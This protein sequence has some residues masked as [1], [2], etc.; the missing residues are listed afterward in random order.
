VREDDWLGERL[1]RTAW[2]VEDCDG[3]EEIT[4]CGSGFFQAKVSAEWVARVGEL[5][6]LGFRAIDVNVILRRDAGISEIQ[7]DLR[8]RDAHSRDRASVL[9][10]ATHDYAVSRFHLDPA[11]PDSV[12]SAIKRDWVDNFFR[13]GRGDRLLVVDTHE[14]PAGFLLVV[15]T[16]EAS[17]IDLIAVATGAQGKGAGSALVAGLVQ[18][19]SDKPVVVGTQV[20]NTRA[21]RFYERLGFTV[22][23]TQFVLHLHA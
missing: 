21:L 20:A 13:G 23:R 10:I 19:R 1:G 15:E 16:P 18:A 17:V 5:E 6:A 7:S 12:A 8:V 14:E 3:V 2:T 22:Q 11:I 4:A 9:A